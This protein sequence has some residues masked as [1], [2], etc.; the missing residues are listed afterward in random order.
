[1]Q[2]R[3]KNGQSVED[4]AARQRR[5]ILE[6]A[7]MD[8]LGTS[9]VEDLPLEDADGPPRHGRH[10]RHDG[11]RPDRLTMP[12][13]APAVSD[14]WA[15]AQRQGV[16]NDDDAL[17]VKDLDPL[18]GGRLYAT[19]QQEVAALGNRLIHGIRDHAQRVLN[20]ELESRLAKQY[21]GRG[22]EIPP[23][24]KINIGKG[25]KTSALGVL[26]HEAQPVRQF[27]P[28]YQPSTT[29]PKTQVPVQ[30][31]PPSRPPRPSS[32]TAPR[33]LVPPKQGLPSSRN[34]VASGATSTAPR[35]E[36]SRASSIQARLLSVV[37]SQTQQ[38]PTQHRS[39]VAPKAS[40][41]NS[42][43]SIRQSSAPTVQD[44]ARQ[45]LQNV[46]LAPLPVTESPL[47]SPELF[48]VVFSCEVNF[49]IPP[50]APDR[51]S[52]PPRGIIYL[53]AAERPHLGFFTL[54]R[55]G[56]LDGQWPIA[57]YHYHSIDSTRQ[58][59]VI[60]RAQ[61]GVTRDSRKVNF[62]SY[63]DAEDFH[64]TLKRLQAGEYLE[65]VNQSSR[66]VLEHTAQEATHATVEASP[67]PA[68]QNP[69]SG[70]QAGHAS[71]SDSDI[72]V[73]QPYT[74][75]PN[76]AQAGNQEVLVGTLIDF[77]T[78]DDDT[79][80]VQP[81]YAQSEAAE[82]LSTLDPVDYELENVDN[83][84]EFQQAQAEAAEQNYGIEVVKQEFVDRYRELLQNLIKVLGEQPKNQTNRGASTMIEGLE[85]C[86]TENAMA[87]QCGLDDTTKRELLREIF[88]DS[89]SVDADNS[90]NDIQSASGPP[91]NLPETPR[92]PPSTAST[93]PTS[94]WLRELAFMPECS[95][96]NQPPST[97]QSLEATL[98]AAT[99][100]TPTPLP[101]A[102]SAPL[103]F[104]RTRASH[105]W[106][107]AT[108]ASNTVRSTPTSISESMVQEAKEE[109]QEPQIKELTPVVSLETT[110]NPSHEE[111]VDEDIHSV[112]ELISLAVPEP[113][114]PSS[115]NNNLRG[116]RGSRWARPD[117][118]L[119]TEGAFT[120]PQ[121]WSR[122]ALRELAQLEPLA[123]VQAT[124]AELAEMFSARP[125]GQNVEHVTPR[126]EVAQQN[127]GPTPVPDHQPATPVNET[128]SIRGLTPQEQT[129][130]AT[131]RVDDA[132]IQQA[133]SISVPPSQV[134]SLVSSSSHANRGLAGF[135]FAISPVP[136]SS[137]V[138]APPQPEQVTLASYPV[139][140][141]LAGFR[142]ARSSTSESTSSTD[143][144]AVH[145]QSKPPIVEAQPP[146]L[147]PRPVNRGLAG[148]RFASGQVLSSS[149]SFTG[150]Y[151]PRT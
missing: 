56:D 48:N 77:D 129:P 46:D 21:H 145:V 144:P 70:A 29:R 38:A 43:S 110:G 68:P 22:R 137:F 52:V 63:M 50:R 125:S 83:H 67:T 104:S 33:Q 16:F 69:V 20:P 53:S 15:E 99:P 65:Q 34:G 28:G 141:S 149:G 13:P 119:E 100:F 59:I 87:D 44:S 116:L 131:Q 66:Q 49:P 124:P 7:M 108:E 31:L 102:A 78:Y 75:N 55:D 134:E 42:A 148:S 60:F 41:Q 89:E 85:T 58:L 79:S 72:V 101:A 39:T 10:D 8:D 24:R 54:T 113:I 133:S 47:S 138:Q 9:R 64:K 25:M 57:S 109:A 18:G 115:T 94:H 51:S 132:T 123:Q 88:G 95:R 117:D 14:F 98:S 121:F 84:L 11:R 146:A 23:N 130:R 90:T 17:A 71:T 37:Q 2:D 92:P 45:Q 73:S 150:M 120:G 142:F 96:R 6:K 27:P 135:R 114:R 80:T 74:P 112:P 61:D 147:D 91:T 105:A 136:Q 4:E 62:T 140:L 32:S 12:Q 106:V 86:V 103:D 1:M 128:S 81:D 118:R 111:H 126:L 26:Y 93:T 5:A 143:S 127:D 36:T 76:T 35:T 40:R 122:T 107:M 30:T 82:L 97:C 3:D 19:R 151:H 139:N